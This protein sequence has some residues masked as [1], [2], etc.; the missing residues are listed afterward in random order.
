MKVGFTG[1]QT[2]MTQNQILA[3]AGLLVDLLPEEVHHGDCIGADEQFDR[4]AWQTGIPRV[5]HPP[6][7][8]AKR[9]H[10]EAQMI[11]EPKPYLDRNR[12][13]VDDTEFLI[14]TPKTYVEARRSGTWYTVRYA[15]KGDGNIAIVYPDGRVDIQRGASV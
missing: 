5:S 11:R 13:I 3:V 8:D 10:C 7:K 9:A 6:D 4:I 1:T 2:G 12:D 14:A 15:R